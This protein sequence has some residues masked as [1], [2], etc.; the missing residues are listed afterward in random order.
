MMLNVLRKC[1][2]LKNLKSLP[3]SGKACKIFN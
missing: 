1:V 3:E 2:T